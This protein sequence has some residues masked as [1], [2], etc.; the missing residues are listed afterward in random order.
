MSEI[1]LRAYLEEIDR[2]IDGNQTDE[3]IAHAKH[4]LTIFPKHLGAYRLL[5]KAL[6]EKSRH[7]DAA[8]V[9]QRVLSSVPDDFVAHV[10]MSIVREDEGSTDAAI[11]HMERAFEAQPANGPIQEELRRLYGR[12]D[13]T[14]PSTVRLTR[15]ALAR[16]YE[17]G[18]L[19]A[20][21]IAELRAALAADPDRLDLK[22]LLAQ[23][24]WHARQQP[25][26]AEAAS[27]I[28]EVLPYCRDAN[29]IMA[30]VW[31][32]SGQTTE[33]QPYRQR[34]QDLDPYE[35]YADPSENGEGASNVPADNI[36]LPR[37]DYSAP[38]LAADT[39]RPAW[40]QSIG[41]EFEKPQAS[42]QSAQVPDWLSGLEGAASPAVAGTGPF[43]APAP[44]PG[45]TD[46]LNSLRDE[47][48]A[49]AQPAAPSAPDT[50]WL[51]D[52]LD[53]AAAPAAQPAEPD[54]FASPQTALPDWVSEPGGA[55]A[56]G[57]APLAGAA[58]APSSPQ[59]AASDTPDWM[60]DVGASAGTEPFS[61]QGTPAAPAAEIPDWMASAG[62]APRDPST[63]LDSAES[64]PATGDEAP[65]EAAPLASAEVPDWLKP[66]FKKATGKLKPPSP[67]AP[68]PPDWMEK[69]APATSSAGD[70]V[71]AALAGQL[72]DWLKDMGSDELPPPPPPPATT[73]PARP[74]T[75]P[76]AETPKVSD[77]VPDWLKDIGPDTSG[78]AVA[79]F[80]KSKPT[81]PLTGPFPSSTQPAKPVTKPFV[82]PPPAAPP[83][84]APEAPTSASDAA[85]AALPDWLKSLEGSPTDTVGKFLRSKPKT[86]AAPVAPAAPAAPAAEVPGSSE[87]VKE[88]P[89]KAPEPLADAD[90]PDWLKSLQGSPTDTVVNFL[91]SKPSAPAADAAI[92]AKPESQAPAPPPPAASAPTMLG[93]SRTKPAPA[94]PPEEDMAWLKPGEAPQPDTG[95]LAPADLPDW[96]K[97]TQPPK[98]AEAPALQPSPSDE[99]LAWLST[100]TPAAELAPPAPSRPVPP[101]DETQQPDWL[102][103]IS[104]PDADL[105]DWLK[106]APAA[107]PEPATAEPAA[108]S[109]DWQ[110]PARPAPVEQLAQTAA[111]DQPSAEPAMDLPDGLLERA[112]RESPQQPAEPAAP[113]ELPDWLKPPAVA[114]Q[115]SPEA[116]DAAAP[117]RMPTDE[118][119]ADL[120]TGILPQHV[121]SDEPAEPS[122]PE[123][124]A[125]D[126]LPAWMRP[127]EET[128]ARAEFPEWM[129]QPTMADLNQT[130]APAAPAAE[131]IPEWLA[132]PQE[133]APLPPMD[134]AQALAWLESLAAGQGAKPEELLTKPQHRPTASPDWLR[135]AAMPPVP[136]AEAAAPSPL[137]ELPDWLRTP[138]EPEETPALPAPEPALSSADALPDWLRAPEETLPTAPAPQAPAEPGL[139]DW[140]RAPAEAVQPPAPPAAEETIPTWLRSPEEPGV[141][142]AA[143]PATSEEDAFAWL[144]SLTVHQGAKAEDEALPTETPEWLRAP[145]EPEPAPEPVAAVVPPT[146]EPAPEPVVPVAQPATSDEDAFA[147]LESL[148][149]QQGGKA[150]EMLTQPESRPTET[151]EWLRAPVEPEPAPEPVAAFV[152]PMPEPEPVPEPVA[153]VVPPT[154]EPEPTP[155][156]VAAAQP[157]AIEPEP[158]VELMETAL[159][160]MAEE[161][162][163]AWLES[164]AMQQGAKPEELLTQPEAR[165]TE[166]PEWLRAPAEAAAPPPAAAPAPEPPVGEKPEWLKQME[167]EADAYE[168]MA[169]GAPVAAPAAVVPEPVAVEAPPSAISPEVPAE[170]EWGEGGVSEAAFAVELPAEGGTHEAAPA[171]EALIEEGRVGEEAFEPEPVVVEAPPPQPEPEL[172]P[173][174]SEPAPAQPEAAAPV[175]AEPLPHDGQP[176]P[177]KFRK[178]RPS[179]AKRAPAEEPQ[180]LLAVARERLA[181]A[182]IGQAVDV[183]AQVLAA[184]HLAPDV[185]A[186]LEAANEKHANTPELMR[187]LGD[188][189]MQ[190]NQLQRALDMYK[191]ALKQ[192]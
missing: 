147:W 146:P 21:A 74:V 173:A 49:P 187:A 84:P 5:A 47:P 186:D 36:R 131:E 127:V 71:V 108:E 85:I 24:L 113:G 11:W 133:A 154:P 41:V 101:P 61:V 77:E 126:E 122:A 176:K 117:S 18:S 125:P 66:A 107:A 82:G 123:A 164:M 96:L 162:A 110:K 32:T 151:P 51:K 4:I 99:D 29:R 38:D 166:T 73:L 170:A 114:E 59:P 185:I 178:P 1:S 121:R 58:S 2:L 165:P 94:L 175:A 26:A 98:P 119:A 160:A 45:G 159:P 37:L 3:A 116:L 182:N 167:A 65:A 14:E 88:Q 140:L 158:P 54:L 139:P 81:G 76:F 149:M 168:A 23:T 9:F 142:P 190:D 46:W 16:L 180:I 75:K 188:A 153:A 118:F 60:K 50:G 86:P 39:S 171:A 28:L 33:A 79:D 80:L 183:Y 31:L 177:P 144:E 97:A 69:S 20:Q 174:V 10:G 137:A 191:L 152:P 109:P 56:A 35:A 130:A 67:S 145:V 169:K 132:H 48:P 134:D 112:I 27:R 7:L 89:P 124:A 150:E 53:G 105:P 44:V 25:E 83:S 63:P 189:Y 55:M 157:P 161:D 172:E 102:T 92:P 143:Q 34:L 156:P 78:D 6:L 129:G 100:I 192:L 72:P 181:E 70:S 40:M 135:P 136:S 64:N 128:P 103:D 120:D 19:Y 184:G 12:R 115:L 91:K 179:R 43:A 8:D 22:V 62:W 52:L 148:A 95:S 93:K 141:P 163:F 42:A 90:L 57:T 111:L 30:D 13:G 138:V 15:A 68:P 17:K 106:P 87:P 104:E 155:E